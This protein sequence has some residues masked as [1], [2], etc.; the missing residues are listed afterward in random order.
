MPD[1]INFQA[2]DPHAED[3]LHLRLHRARS[4]VLTSEER[5]QKARSYPESSSHHVDALPPRLSVE[6]SVRAQQACCRV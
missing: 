1:D 5:N 6:F 3:K 2:F 4:V